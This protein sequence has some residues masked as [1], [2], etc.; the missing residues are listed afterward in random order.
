MA[1]H[2]RTETLGD[3]LRLPN[4]TVRVTCTACGR[5]GEFIPAELLMAFGRNALVRR[6][7]RFVCSG[8]GSRHVRTE[9]ARLV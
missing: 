4:A 7:G 8:C 5:S 9:A 2:K 1:A 6:L 3:L